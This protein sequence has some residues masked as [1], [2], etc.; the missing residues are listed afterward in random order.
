MVESG[1]LKAEEAERIFEQLDALHQEKRNVP[2][3]Q[4]H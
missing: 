1:R 4:T 3:G 2:S